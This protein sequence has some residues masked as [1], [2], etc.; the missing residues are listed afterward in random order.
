MLSRVQAFSCC[1]AWFWVAVWRAAE[2]HGEEV[3]RS[4][5]CT[6]FISQLAR[7]LP[8]TSQWWQYPT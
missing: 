4:W 6:C 1:W 2:G 3:N 5:C 8:H 7:N